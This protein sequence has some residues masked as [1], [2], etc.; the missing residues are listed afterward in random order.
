M[1]LTMKRDIEEYLSGHREELYEELPE[2]A[3][4]RFLQ[5]LPSQ[6]EEV[7]SP[8]PAWT[9]AWKMTVALASIAA[10]AVLIAV[11][12]SSLSGIGRNYFVGTGNDPDK[13]YSAYLD[14]LETFSRQA[15][16]NPL[17]ETTI[18]S[19]SFEAIPL[20]LQLPDEMPSARKANILKQ[21]YGA[22]LD[23]LGKAVKDPGN[24]SVI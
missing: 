3:M 24:N 1:G 13:V 12:A 23:G 5:R 8:T 9:R 19:I 14:H 21:H 2:G 17:L 11:L 20:L 10:A 4:E 7:P 6:E 18:E 16:Q 22:I 15:D